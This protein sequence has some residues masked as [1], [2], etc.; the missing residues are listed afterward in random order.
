MNL[1]AKNMPYTGLMKKKHNAIAYH[2]VREA[3]SAKIFNLAHIKS[4][5]NYAD[6]LTKSVNGAVHAKLVRPLLFQRHVSFCGE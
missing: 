1:F 6:I 2:S 4:E 5:D 3:V